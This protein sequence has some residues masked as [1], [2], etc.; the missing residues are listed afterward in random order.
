MKAVVQN[1]APNNSQM[2]L[3]NPKISPIFREV[4]SAFAPLPP[5]NEEAA[6]VFNLPHALGDAQPSCDRGG[7]A[8]RIM[9]NAHQSWMRWHDHYVTDLPF[10][11][12]LFPLPWC[13]STL[14]EDFVRG[15]LRAISALPAQIQ[16]F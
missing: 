10:L 15:P 4:E 16:A 6:Q 3:L 8:M 2:L 5:K 14:L 1:N 13:E 11:E 12:A 7:I 9:R